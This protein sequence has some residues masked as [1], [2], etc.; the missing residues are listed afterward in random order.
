MA[1][2]RGKEFE[3]LFKR[4]CEDHHVNCI[5]F[6]DV[7][8]GFKSVNNPCDFVISKDRFEMSLLVECKSTNSTSFSLK[9][10][11]HDL[12]ANLDNF[13]SLVLVWFIK[14]KEIWALS[15]QNILQMEKDGLNSFNPD[16]HKKYGQKITT[17]FARIKPTFMNVLELW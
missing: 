2:N 15:I 9:F 16:K 5:R 17:Y 1:A 11:Q 6:H 4:F 7:M 13:N 14:R 3:D 8:Q 10:R 12:L